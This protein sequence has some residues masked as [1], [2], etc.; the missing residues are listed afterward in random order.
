[1]A[2]EGPF[3]PKPC[4]DSMSLL[5]RPCTNADPSSAR[6]GDG[7]STAPPARG[8]GVAPDFGGYQAPGDAQSLFWR[9]HPQ[10][11]HQPPARG[12][13]GRGKA[14]DVPRSMGHRWGPSCP[15]K[16][17]R[18]WHGGAAGP[19][20]L[21]RCICWASAGCWARGFGRFPCRGGHRRRSGSSSHLGQ[22]KSSPCPKAGSG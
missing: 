7:C 13:C 17:D 20:G 5:I 8:S 22:P 10:V 4:Y 19:L 2:F 11:R 9:K 1:M 18:R 14:L 21:C 6:A 12:G 16:A 3:Q 15:V